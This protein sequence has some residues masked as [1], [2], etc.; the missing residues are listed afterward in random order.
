MSKNIGWDNFLKEQE[1]KKEKYIDWHH[2]MDYRTTEELMTELNNKWEAEYN[3]IKSI[4]GSV[5]PLDLAVMFDR[6]VV[7]LS[8][9]EISIKYNGY[10]I[11]D[12]K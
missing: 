12:D 10:I 11:P 2:G 3:R 5:F 4:N 8:D 6:I 7:G 9:E 1:E